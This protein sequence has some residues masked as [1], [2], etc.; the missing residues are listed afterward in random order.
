MTEKQQQ[1]DNAWKIQKRIQL[2][3]RR[4]DFSSYD[5]MRDFLDGLEELSEQEIYY[6][7]L[8]F[9]RTHVNVSIK[10][11]GDELAQVDFD[12]STKVDDLAGASNQ[13]KQ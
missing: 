6:P 10:A 9:S 12:F 11:R 2:M 1:T 13:E 7:D 3:S 5:D 8:T 4:Y